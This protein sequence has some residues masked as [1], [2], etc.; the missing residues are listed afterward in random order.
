MFEVR[1]GYRVRMG[2]RVGGRVG[3][4][5]RSRIEALRVNVTILDV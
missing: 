4:R 1:V 2:G 5:A 3:V